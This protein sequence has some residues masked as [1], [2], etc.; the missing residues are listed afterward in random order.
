MP[1]KKWTPRTEVNDS[2][3]K[4]REKRRWQIAL[5]RYV[6]ARNKSSSYAPFFGLDIDNFRKWIEIQ[7]DGKLNWE[8]FSENWQFDHVIPVTYFDFSKEEDLK[9]CWN[10][11]NIRVVPL[12]PEKHLAKRLDLAA[13]K[14]YF[15]TLYVKT[16][17]SPCFKMVEKINQIE[18]SEISHPAE[19]EE[20]IHQHK[21]Y[22]ETISGF[23]SYEFEQLNKG[24][25]HMDVL[26]EREFLKQFE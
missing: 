5:R 23:N 7:F 13:A 10:F 4:F 16:Q 20:F 9:L 14:K 3:L 15:V 2:V 19:L 24:A 21:T 22:L 1:R 17:Y 8:N 12:D 6:L 18:A 26:K 11:I 25:N